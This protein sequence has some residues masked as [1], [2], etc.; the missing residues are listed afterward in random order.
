MNELISQVISSTT[1]SM[2][3]DGFLN[4]AL[5]DFGN[6][7]VPYLRLKFLLSSLSPIVSSDKLYYESPSISSLS[8]ICL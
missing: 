6:N 1:A 8:E 5:G 2:R 3:F 7:L 4:N